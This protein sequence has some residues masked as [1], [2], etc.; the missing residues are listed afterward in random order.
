MKDGYRKHLYRML[1]ILKVW[2]YPLDEILPL[3]QALAGRSDAALISALEILIDH[4]VDITPF[5]PEMR[6]LINQQNLPTGFRKGEKFLLALLLLKQDFND[7]AAWSYLDQ[8]IANVG[9]SRIE[10]ESFECSLIHILAPRSSQAQNILDKYS[11]A[12]QRPSTKYMAT[13][14]RFMSKYGLLDAK[15][16]RSQIQESE[17]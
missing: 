17:R 16:T 11:W 2:P 8:S 15:E 5:L 12:T 1:A 10:I 6:K 3:L 13:A 9:I 7:S 14:R 4:Q